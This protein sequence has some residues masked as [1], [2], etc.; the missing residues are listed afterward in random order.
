M[1]LKSIR[2]I[3][4]RN[5]A[6]QDIDLHP[7][8]NLFYGANAQGKTNILESIYLTARGRSFKNVPDRELVRFGQRSAYVLSDLERKG[9][10]KRV[11]VKISRV[12]RKRIRINEV[13]MENTR[14]LKDQFEVVLFAPE[15]LTLVQGGPGER[16]AF[17]DDLLRSVD[18]A[19]PALLRS[20]EKVLAQ[21]NYL[22]KSPKDG[23]FDRQLA[24]YDDQLAQAGSQITYKRRAMVDE[25]ASL[26]PGFQKDLS[27]Q[28]EDLTLFYDSHLLEDGEALGPEEL[29]EK[30]KDLLFQQRED[31]LA[32]GHTGIG[33]HKDDL[34]FNLNG[35]SSRKFA[36]QGQARTMTLA[37]KL[38]E[39]KILEK[40]KEI[41][42]LLL[43][44]DVFSEL[45]KKRSAYLLEAIGSYQTILTSNHPIEGGLE[46]RRFRVEAGEIHVDDK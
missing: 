18:V 34:V 22:L 6:F 40:Y 23:W 5:I 46:G 25:I 27:S 15:N 3:N 13:E 44:D 43:L 32:L 10:D 45:D 30:M 39:L 37:L 38:S 41:P 17:L 28:A 12:E 1:I 21:R 31:D 19:Y 4:Y 9:R 35:L 14:E 33:P 16:R 2:L 7:H 42:P 24:V 36:S 20:Y 26:A 29:K 8:W 11:E